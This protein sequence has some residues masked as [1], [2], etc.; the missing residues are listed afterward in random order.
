MP[1]NPTRKTEVQA[2]RFEVRRMNSALV[3][4]DA[5]MLHDPLRTHSRATM[6][7]V[8]LSAIGLLGFLVFG[9]L[10]PAA[11][12]PSNGIVIGKE[13]G[14][15]FVKV[16]EPKEMLIPTFNLA[17]ARLILMGQQP[18]GEGEAAAAAQPVSVAEPVV[19]P[20][21]RLVDIPRGRPQGIPGAHMQLPGKDQ[22]ISDHWSV[23][24]HLPL[25]DDLPESERLA[26]AKKSQETAVLAGVS[27]LGKPLESNV[28]LLVERVDGELY[29]I[30]RPEE[31]ANRKANMVRASIPKSDPSVMEA[32]QL[33]GLTTR[34]MSMG[35]LNSI[36]EVGSLEAP[37][38]EGLNQEID[39]ELDGRSAKVGDVFAVNHPGKT[40]YYVVLVDGK[41]RVTQ[42]VASMIRHKHS[43]DTKIPSIAPSRLQEMRDSPTPMPVDDYPQQIPTVL[44]PL[45]HPTTC[46]GW[47]LSGSGQDRDGRTTMYYGNELP[48]PKDDAGTPQ[49]V[50]VGKANEEKIVV[51]YFSMPPGRGAVVHAATSKSSFKSGPI[52]LISDRGMRYGIPD[53]KTADSLGLSDRRPA[54]EN[55]IKLLPTAVSLNLQAASATYDSVQVVGGT[56][57]YEGQETGTDAASGG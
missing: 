52:Q 44:D 51:N 6:V 11:K 15:I 26:E 21:D 22:R 5:V 41:Q 39:F 2:Y 4:K 38:I 49:R 23:C 56:A 25:R 17:S 42:A 29:L 47:A 18:S 24:H 35:L 10:K 54:P 37:H 50:K 46:V 1:S 3:R 12:P 57:S 55:I 43:T 20:D 30:Y 45:K 28:A 32:L 13:S 31:T 33:N 19:V 53:T 27:N 7:G 16:A 34:P 8:I 9:I 14:Q 48:F 40:D 36:Q